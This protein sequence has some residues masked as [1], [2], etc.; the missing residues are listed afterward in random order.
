MIMHRWVT[1][2]VLCLVILTAMS[3]G[4][5]ENQR[6]DLSYKENPIKPTVIFPHIPNATAPSIVPLIPN[7][8]SSPPTIVQ[9]PP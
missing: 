5:C 8:T 1:I 9:L 4:N 6:S 7:V 2:K 3:A